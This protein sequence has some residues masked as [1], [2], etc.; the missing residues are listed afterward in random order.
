MAS[1]SLSCENKQ[2]SS[3]FMPAFIWKPSPAAHTNVFSEK[4]SVND[5]FIKHSARLIKQ[6]LVSRSNQNNMDQVASAASTGKKVH[7]KTVFTSNLRRLKRRFW[8][9]LRHGI[10]KTKQ[11]QRLR[12]EWRLFTTGAQHHGCLANCRLFQSLCGST[13]SLWCLPS[14]LDESLPSLE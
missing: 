7:Q 14:C 4:N 13:A 10:K 12:P 2:H 9:D 8:V 5:A 1:A 11:K 6:Q 3:Q